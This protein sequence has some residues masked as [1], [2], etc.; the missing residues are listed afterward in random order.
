V[1]DSSPESAA[2]K[3]ARRIAREHGLPPDQTEWYE[4]REAERLGREAREGRYPEV[5][6]RPARKASAVADFFAVDEIGDRFVQVDGE[7]VVSSGGTA[8]IRSLTV[9]P[10]NPREDFEI[11][12]TMLRQVRVAEIRR[13]ALRAIFERRDDF[14]AA[15][16]F[17]WPL[18]DETETRAL[19]EA[20]EAAE[21]PEKRPG[22]TG[23]PADH[24]RRIA[25]AYLS[26]LEQGYG[27]GVLKLLA[28]AESK[29]LGRKVPRETVRDWVRGA[30][31]RGF[32]TGGR[33]GRAGAQAG[34]KLYERREEQ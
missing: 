31:K 7:L 3:T 25:L 19:E 20:V 8:A 9:K 24:Y 12:S 22:R 30:R 34:P 2:R 17:G 26:L 13:R 27:R 18:P 29:R 11:T 4:E 10:Y 23:Y 14:E 21:L 16:R 5:T 1:A 6:V 15:Q 33:Q 32:L 28:E